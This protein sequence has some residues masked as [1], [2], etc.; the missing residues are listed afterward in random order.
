MKRVFFFTIAVFGL[1]SQIVAQEL[2]D[3]R[4]GQDFS[5]TDHVGCRKFMPFKSG[6]NVVF[7]DLDSKTRIIGITYSYESKKA[8]KAL[9]L[10]YM[11]ECKFKKAVFFQDKGTVRYGTQKI[12]SIYSV[13]VID[14]NKKDQLGRSVPCRVSIP[15]L[16]TDKRDSIG[17]LWELDQ[18]VDEFGD[19]VGEQYCALP[20]VNG[21]FSNTATSGSNMFAKLLITKDRIMFKLLEYD[22]NPVVGND[23]FTILIKDSEGEKT[24]LIGKQ[25]GEY[26][27]VSD[28]SGE[29][30]T[31]N[32]YLKFKSLLEKGGEMQFVLIGKYKET[33]KFTLNIEG[34]VDIFPSKPWE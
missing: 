5:N 30:Y 18:F 12:G 7:V 31:S 24:V 8:A 25:S 34:Y 4:L 19:K 23:Y 29:F 22:D 33:Y 16:V 28:N 14:M 11:R 6:E 21:V 9:A 2:G 13:V 1:L 26:I 32:D 3:Y 17:G 15:K 27:A 20:Y 10:N